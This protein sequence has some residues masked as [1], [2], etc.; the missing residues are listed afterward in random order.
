LLQQVYPALEVSHLVPDAFAVDL[1]P[2]CCETVALLHENISVKKG[3]PYATD[4]LGEECPSKMA[5]QG[6]YSA[7]SRSTSVFNHRRE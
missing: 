7:S 5:K 2:W 3:R 4:A 6:K 1:P